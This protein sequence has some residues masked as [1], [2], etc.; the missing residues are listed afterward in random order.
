[1][2]RAMS[3]I[4]RRTESGVST[5]VGLCRLVIT[6]SRVFGVMQSRTAFGSTAQPIFFSARETFH[7]SVKILGDV[8]NRS[9][10]RMLD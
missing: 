2:L 10:C 5:L 3:P 8:Q 6:M 9:V 4:S 7:F 1:M